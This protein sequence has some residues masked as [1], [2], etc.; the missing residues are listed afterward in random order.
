MKERP[1]EK[2]E[3]PLEEGGRPEKRGEG[4]GKRGKVPGNRGEGPGKRGKGPGKRGE[5]LWKKGEDP[6]KRVELSTLYIPEKISI[7]LSHSNILKVGF[8]VN[9]HLKGTAQ[10]CPYKN[11]TYSQIDQ[12]DQIGI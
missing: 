4:S 2:K 5:G 9:Q 11:K 1:W 3:R 7:I 12:I 10:C 6:G 8:R